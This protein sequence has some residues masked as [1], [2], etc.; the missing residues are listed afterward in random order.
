[1]V[2]LITLDRARS[3][4]HIEGADEDEELAAKIADAS[5]IVI[6]Y[7]K[8]PDHGWTDVT[9]PGQVQAATLLVLGAIWSQREGVGQGADD[10]DPISPAV[11]SLLRRMR[12][13]ALA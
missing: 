3:H 11:V 7:L 10:L 6:D 13:P 4:L 5:G 12:D 8:R 2:D 9:A 1:M